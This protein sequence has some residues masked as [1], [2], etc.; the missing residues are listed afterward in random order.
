VRLL[1]CKYVNIVFGVLKSPQKPKQEPSSPDASIAHVTSELLQCADDTGQGRK[2][3]G[4]VCHV[5]G[6][7]FA[8]HTMPRVLVFGN[9]FERIFFVEVTVTVAYNAILFLKAMRAFPV[10]LIGGEM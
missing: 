6:G 10:H 8:D 9:G 3:V 7:I 1:W 4:L 5:P 2:F